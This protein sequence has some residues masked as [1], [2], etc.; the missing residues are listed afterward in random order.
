MNYKEYSYPKRDKNG[1]LFVEE[2]IKY[3]TNTCRIKHS[4]LGLSIGGEDLVHEKELQ[5]HSDLLIL[6]DKEKYDAEWMRIPYNDNHFDYVF[7]KSVI[8]HISNTDLFLSEIY[9]VLKPGGKIIILTPD[10]QKQKS[11]FYDDYTHIKPFT[12][13]SLKMA[14]QL[15]GFTIMIG[16]WFYYYRKIWEGKMFPNGLNCRLGYWLTE[17]TKIKYFRW[18]SDRQLFV[19]GLK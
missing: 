19:V 8:E 4:D 10:Y 11:F 6:N 1:L 17:K 12:L 18:G 7:I 5:C 13:N 2:L 14:V 15:N 3:I 9:R 16:K